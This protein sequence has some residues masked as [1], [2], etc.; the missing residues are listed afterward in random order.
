MLNSI[1]KFKV[2]TKIL[3]PIVLILILGNIFINFKSATK[4]DEVVRENTKQSMDMLTDSV[5]LTLRNAMNTG[6]PD[7]IKQAEEQ[8]RSSIKGLNSLK[9]YKSQNTIDMYSP[10]EQFTQD[11]TVLKSFET[12]EEMVIDEYDNESHL[13]KVLRPMIATQECLMCHAN[14]SVG[15]VIGV[16]ELKFGLDTA[17]AMIKESTLFLYGIS[18]VIIALTLLSVLLVVNKVTSPLKTLQEELNLFFDFILHKTNE[19]KPFQVHSKDEIGQM[20]E[21]INSSIEEIVQ[22]VK[23]DQ[24]AIAQITQTCEKASFGNLSVQINT[25]ANNASINNLT[26]IINSL[27]NSLN[28]NVNRVLKTLDAYSQD[29]FNARINSS[30]KTSGEVKQLFKQVDFLGETLVRLS[31][32]NLK[33]GMALQEKSKIFANNVD[34]LAASS[35]NQKASLE[36]ATKNLNVVLQKTNETTSNAKLMEQYALDV[37]QSSQKGEALANKTNIAMDEINQKVSTINE[38]IEIIDQIAFQTNIL[39]LNAAVEAATA[40][41]VGKGF[42]VVAQEVRNL[43]SRSAEAAK[44]IKNLVQNATVQTSLGKEIATQMKDEYLIL[45][46]NI[47]NTTEIIKKVTNDSQEQNINLANIN[48]MIENINN[49]TKN[50]AKI[51]NDT[52]I[53]AKEANEIAQK[54]VEDAGGKE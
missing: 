16:I 12:K 7:I 53:V 13:L 8:S 23:K 31:S 19:I 30:G 2:S 28:Y 10:T 45:N 27:L 17:D 6:D 1:N 9:V 37:T 15:N 29:N 25:E 44:E 24:E 35:N 21:S 41:E 36:E 49:E 20:V 18:F 40:G 39:S 38:A 14:E 32:Q 47:T 46:E 48:A 51:A 33:N 42:A 5:F 22:G 26:T 34:K 43:A 54:I 50:N 11:S 52:N 4:M 3:L